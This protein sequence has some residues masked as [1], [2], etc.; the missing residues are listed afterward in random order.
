MEANETAQHARRILWRFSNTQKDPDVF[1][2]TRV[3]YGDRPAGCIA[4]AVVQETAK[5][6]GGSREEATLFLRNRTYVDDATRGAQDDR[7]KKMLVA[8][9]KTWKAS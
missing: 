7:M 8:Y 6:F 5:R 1:R 2:T 9:H 3:N 4:M